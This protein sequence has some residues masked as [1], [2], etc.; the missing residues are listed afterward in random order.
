MI[1]LETVR[2]ST[3]LLGLALA[4]VLS[5]TTTAPSAMAQNT[6]ADAVK[7]DNFQIFQISG[8]F[9][10]DAIRLFEPLPNSPGRLVWVEPDGGVKSAT[11]EDFLRLVPTTTNEVSPRK[12]QKV[13]GLLTVLFRNVE[14]TRMFFETDKVATFS[15]VEKNAELEI[16]SVVISDPGPPPPTYRIAFAWRYMKKAKIKD[17]GSAVANAMEGQEVPVQLAG[18]SMEDDI[19][20]KF[21][22]EEPT[23]PPQ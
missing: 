8:N 10:V 17:T 13:K 7:R 22:V 9:K 20:V 6:T 23:A 14:L 5:V 12:P 16:A 18:S 11:D 19:K 1:R 21:L 4:L 15:F 3:L 2:R